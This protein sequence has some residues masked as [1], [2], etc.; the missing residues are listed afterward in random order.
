MDLTADNVNIR[1]LLQAYNLN[2]SE[3]ELRTYTNDLV[4]RLK[5]VYK[6]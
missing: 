2:N 3:D 4:A 1:Y 6:S 5:G